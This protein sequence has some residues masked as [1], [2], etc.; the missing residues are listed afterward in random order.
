MYTMRKVCIQKKVKLISL[1]M[2]EREICMKIEPR[3]VAVAK[4]VKEPVVPNQSRY[5]CVGCVETSCDEE[6][7]TL[8]KVKLVRTLRIVSVLN[9]VSLASL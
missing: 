3:I 7:E 5:C 1:R 2:K 4:S 8:A 6:Y 9:S